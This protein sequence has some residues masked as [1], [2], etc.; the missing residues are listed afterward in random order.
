MNAWEGQAHQ[1]SFGNQKNFQFFMQALKDEHSDG[2]EP[3]PAWFKAFVAKA[4][5][6]RATLSI[7][8]TRKFAAFQANIVA[9]TIACL[10]LGVRRTH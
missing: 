4:I 5:L 1:V 3:D 2:F 7:V 10:S 6:F 8:R 9:Y